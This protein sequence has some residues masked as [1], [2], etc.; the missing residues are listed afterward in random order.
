M[1]PLRIPG[2]WS[3]VFYTWT[4]TLISKASHSK[5]TSHDVIPVTQRY[6]T[7]R[8]TARLHELWLRHQNSSYRWVRMVVGF[9]TAFVHFSITYLAASFCILLNPL[10][11]GWAISLLDRG[12]TQRVYVACGTM[13]LVSLLQTVA[14]NYSIFLNTEMS[15]GMR[16]AL[17]GAIYSKVLRMSY[18]ARQGFSRGQLLNLMSVD[19]GKVQALLTNGETLVR[20]PLTMVCAAMLLVWKTGLA[21]AAGFGTLVLFIPVQYLIT[22]HMSRHRQVRPRH[23]ANQPCRTAQ[24]LATG[25]LP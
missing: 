10:L 2:L 20:S 15:H 12:E 8:A 7:S 14:G 19:V 11:L 6:S 23:V 4:N 13:L 24:S 22:T 16:N 9:S 21:A 18:E 25:A 17:A 3:S 1:Q 5:L